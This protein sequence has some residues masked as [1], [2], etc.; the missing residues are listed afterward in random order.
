MNLEK[1]VRLLAEAGAGSGNREDLAE[2]TCWIR[3][4]HRDV[5]AAVS[6]LRTHDRLAVTLS[7]FLRSIVYLVPDCDDTLGPDTT[8][9]L[10]ERLSID[11]E[12][13]YQQT[14]ERVRLGWNPTLAYMCRM[15]ELAKEGG[16]LQGIAQ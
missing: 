13:F 1:P 5:A 16:P 8:T 11:V 4:V 10:L 15:I 12:D 2:S 14:G 3:A 6:R 7:Y 9:Q